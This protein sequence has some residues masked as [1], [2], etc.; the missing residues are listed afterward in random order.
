MTTAA[1]RTM[2]VVVSRRPPWTTT[3]ED[4]R[5]T[6]A[7][8]GIASPM[9]AARLSSASTRPPKT[10]KHSLP[11]CAFTQR[12]PKSLSI[13]IECNAATLGL[14]DPAWLICVGLTPTSSAMQEYFT[15]D[16]SDPPAAIALA[17]FRQ[18]SGL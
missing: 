3:G 1:D 10:S 4:P 8:V 9:V 15:P 16:S 6:P 14:T 12:I 18:S 17:P 7:T 11:H 2:T 13:S 5:Q